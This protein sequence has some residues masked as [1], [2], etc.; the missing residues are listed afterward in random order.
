ML[1]IRDGHR[2]DASA[3][4]KMICDFNVEE[5]SP[6]R[7]SADGVI[8]LCFDDRSLYKPLVAEEGGELVG[9]ALI[10]RYFDTD[11]CAWLSHMQDLFVASAWRSRGVGK[12]LIAAAARYTLDEGRLELAWHVRDHNTRGRAFYQRI[13][14]VEQTHIPVTL[15]G[16]ALE[17]I[18]KEAD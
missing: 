13:G 11:P 12:R 5:G 16:E 14:G 4:A 1:I 3:L 7:V 2:G 8:D 6:G 18:A 9:Y 10:M 17:K 15:L